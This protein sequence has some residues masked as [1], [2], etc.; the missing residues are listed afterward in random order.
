MAPLFSLG[1]TQELLTIYDIL[2]SYRLSLFV[3]IKGESLHFS[4]K[5][6]FTRTSSGYV[7]KGG[8]AQPSKANL[9]LQNMCSGWGSGG[10]NR[11][12]TLIRLSTTDAKL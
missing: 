10:A 2:F 6:E 8:L 1:L 11:H 4:N 7:T 3:L 9:H 12:S 5:S